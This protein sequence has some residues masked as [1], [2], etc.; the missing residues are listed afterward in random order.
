ML[1]S[2]IL[3]PAG[4]DLTPYRRASRSVLAVLSRFGVVEKGLSGSHICRVLQP[5]ATLHMLS[6]RVTAAPDV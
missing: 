1:S 2:D 3:F 6:V 5:D 4:E